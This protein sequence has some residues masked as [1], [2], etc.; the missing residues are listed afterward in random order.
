L[1]FFAFLRG[2]ALLPSTS[3]I[4]GIITFPAA[5][6]YNATKWVIEGLTEPLASEVDT[7]GIKVMLF[8]PGGYATDWR[9][10]SARRA[11][12]MA[13]Y[14]G[15]RDRMRARS[16]GQKLEYPSATTQAILAVV[17]APEPPLRLFLGNV[18]LIV[19]RQ[20][21]ANRVST[22]ASV[23]ADAQGQSST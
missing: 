19:A 14:D 10:S 4:A 3:S 16:A 2:S 18:E 17:D 5:G 21:Y 23:S 6:V 22:W 11:A 20:A 12:P 9:G 1:I 13:E 15:L 7:F 8:E